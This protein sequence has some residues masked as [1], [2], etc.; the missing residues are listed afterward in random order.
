MGLYIGAFSCFGLFLNLRSPNFSWT[1]VSYVTKQSGPV[2]V[3]MFGGWGFCIL[4]GVGGYFLAGAVPVW[5]VL[6]AY[7]LL[8]LLLWLALRGWMKAR[9]T[10][11][12][13]AL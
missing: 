8:F 9:G 3:S 4:S 2:V 11:L 7:A 1:N 10:E 13:A 6:C 12:F 5:A